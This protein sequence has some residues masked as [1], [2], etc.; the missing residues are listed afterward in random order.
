MPMGLPRLEVLQD[1]VLMARD[2]LQWLVTYMDIPDRTE[3][4]AAV[5]AAYHNVVVAS[6]SLLTLG[7]LTTRPWIRLVVWMGG[8]VWTLVSFLAKLLLSNFYYSSIKGFHQAKWIWRMYWSWQISLNRREY[9]IQGSLILTGAIL[10]LLRK[11]IQQKK[12]YERTIGWY[13]AKKRNIIKV[14]G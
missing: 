8:H 6:S 11:Y 12:Y 10:Y 2:Q 3:Y 1:Y 4:I 7:Y 14:C 5:H 13:K 9:L